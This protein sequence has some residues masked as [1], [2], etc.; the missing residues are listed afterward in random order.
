MVKLALFR[1][2][3]LQGLTSVAFREANGSFRGAEIQVYL[4][5]ES[6][7]L[8]RCVS[9]LHTLHTLNMLNGGGR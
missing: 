5:Q 8:Y 6:K 4:M 3:P 7:V 9:T 1:D 2:L